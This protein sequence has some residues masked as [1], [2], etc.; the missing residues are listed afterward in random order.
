M[1]HIK[2]AAMR[3]A[4]RGLLLAATIVAAIP[5]SKG[6]TGFYSYSYV[7]EANLYKVRLTPEFR[8]QL[9][10]ST[11]GRL[12][13][14]ATGDP[15]PDFDHSYTD[16]MHGSLAFSLDSLFY[17]L[18][19]MQEIDLTSMHT[20]DVTVMSNLFWN[21]RSM[22]KVDL[23]HLDTRRVTD[24]NHMF[25]LCE[26]LTEIDLS[27]FDTHQV[28]DMSYMLCCCSALQS[29]Q[30]G[31]GFKTP[32]VTTMRNMLWGCRSLTHINLSTLDTHAVTDMSGML[33]YC[34]SLSSANL[35]N[36]DTRQVTNMS[37]MLAGCSQLST[38]DLSSFDTRRVT[39][40]SYMLK[41]C[42]SLSTLDLSKI[43]THAVI[44]MFEMI[45][46]CKSLKRVNLNGFDTRQV[47]DM[48][49]MIEN[50]D[51]LLFLDLNSFTLCA[52]QELR[53]M[54]AG[55]CSASATSQP[56]PGIAANAAQASVLN[57]PAVTQINLAVLQFDSV[58]AANRGAF[59]T[60]TY[61]SVAGVCHVGLA[62][63]FKAQ[64]N[65][66]AGGYYTDGT[67]QWLNNDPL[68]DF[69]HY[70][71]DGQH[72]RRNYSLAGLLAGL[73]KME[74]ADL[75]QMRTT[76]VTDLS[77]MLEMCHAVKSVDF[78][79]WDTESVTD[80]RNMFAGCVSLNGL[81]LG[82][83]N[84]PVSAD[85]RGMF[86]NTCTGNTTAVP[87]ECQ[88]ATQELARLFN[89][90]SVTGIN[91]SCMRFNEQSA[92]ND[93]KASPQSAAPIFYDL[94]G[95]RVPNPEPGQ[96]YITSRGEKIVYKQ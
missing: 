51:S 55:T 61:D 78:T 49:Y 86:S 53:G 38:I 64:L 33:G 91:L 96:V 87:Y 44:N 42:A 77:A 16:G 76:G 65:R 13:T 43:D 50:C 72:G 24:M 21:C 34:A 26:S 4:L 6:A 69:N 79:G 71:G 47:A 84:L 31:N 5:F 37:E 19:N 85:M 59:Y 1:R 22:R 45:E 2:T 40:M 11:G 18:E 93:I 88:A 7:P 28:T 10:K 95:V 8:A 12:A 94:Q 20:H 90:S 15:V 48:R 60:Y 46:G 74:K 73:D 9:D 75:S 82:P 17:G 63:G 54:L 41:G 27:S 25:Y 52:P 67:L 56:M 35:S 57:D 70:S 68:P 30:L 80:V 62:P 23:S 66:A 32:A 58:S 14:W 39:D 36:F 29:L 81:N 83:L 3:F 89:D 92:V